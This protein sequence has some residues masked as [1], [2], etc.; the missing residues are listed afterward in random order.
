MAF[1][2]KYFLL[3]DWIFPILQPSEASMK[4]AWLL[5]IV[6]TKSILV[7]EAWISQAH[8]GSAVPTPVV[9]PA[10]GARYTFQC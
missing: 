10:V 6:Q 7:P 2:G 1:S 9:L 5:K 4:S 8:S 3:S